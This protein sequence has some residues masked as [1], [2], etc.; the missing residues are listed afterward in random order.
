MARGLEKKAVTHRIGEM[1]R[2]FPD[3]EVRGYENLVETMTCDPKDRHVL[4]AAVRSDAAVLVTFNL[5]DF[6]DT[7]TAAY[8]I[9]VARPVMAYTP[10]SC[11]AGLSLPSCSAA[12]ANRSFRV[13]V[14]CSASVLS[15]CLLVARRPKYCAASVPIRVRKLTLAAVIS[16]LRSRT[17]WSLADAGAVGQRRVR[18]RPGQLT[19]GSRGR[20]GPLCVAKEAGLPPRSRSLTGRRIC[21]LAGTRLFCTIDE[22]R[23]VVQIDQVARLQWL[24]YIS[25]CRR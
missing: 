5:G 13:R 21:G 15:S 20:D 24:W 8:D 11:T 3:A 18:R 6:P 1:S 16:G 12:V 10:A 25:P 22:E 2:A 9:T 19:G 23:R 7:S 17:Y 14:R 4:A